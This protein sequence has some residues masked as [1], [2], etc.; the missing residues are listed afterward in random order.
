MNMRLRS[1]PVLALGGIVLAAAVFGGGVIAGKALEDPEEAPAVAQPNT[2][3][4]TLPRTGPFAAPDRDGGDDSLTRAGWSPYPAAAETGAAS[5]EA[6]GFG[7]GGATVPTSYQGCEAP[8]G[9]VISNGTIDPG[10]AGIVP[11]LL[12]EGFQL[13]SLNLRAEGDCTD[14]GE[15]PTSGRP[16]LDTGWR[17]IETGI[18]VWVTQRI[19]DEPVAN[20]RW[21]TSANVVADGYFFTVNAWNN[22]YYYGT[23]DVKPAPDRADVE[24]AGIAP[25]SGVDPAIAP[26]VDLAL[27]QLAPQVPA[28]C[29]YTQVEGSWADLAAFGVGDPRPA[30]PSGFAESSFNLFTYQ[31][32]DAGCADNGGE[33]PEG[34]SF[35]VQWSGD[36]GR[37]Y[38]EVNV[39]KYEPYEGETWP[40]SL[41][42]WGASWMGNGYQFNVWGNSD[43]GGLGKDVIL[44]IA[45]ALDPS[46]NAQCLVTTT[47]LDAAGLAAIGIG[48][49]SAPDGFSLGRSNLLR[50]GVAAGCPGANDYTSYEVS[51]SFT[52]DSGG[53][54]EVYGWVNG[55]QSNTSD[56]WG[57]VH[58]YGIEWGD[59]N[60]NFSIWGNNPDGSSTRDLVVA[61]ALSIDPSL[62]VDSFDNGGGV[63]PL[64]QPVAEDAPAR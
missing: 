7:Y 44:A 1:W 61:V 59:G 19:F 32:P 30:V 10:A 53:T 64:P 48:A 63:K 62:D 34:N 29:Y 47:N 22:Y 21:E 20:V 33:A 52:N 36:G 31:S 37:S 17:H 14:S 2:F 60:R 49:P 4:S 6:R 3:G 58:D 15:P 46:F 26:V 27:A 57:Y 5:D 40:G 16:V 35:W 50:R 18:T 28:G 38:L 55:N 8:I 51:W 45:T 54:L 24:A 42:D 25:P 11:R 56:S 41:D 9:N 39:Y 43:D 13:L 23:D 12:R